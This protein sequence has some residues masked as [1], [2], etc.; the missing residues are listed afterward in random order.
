MSLNLTRTKSAS[1]ATL[2]S[3]FF[4][5]TTQPWTRPTDWLTLPVLQSTDNQF[6]GLFGVTNDSSNIVALTCTT[7][8]GTYTVDWGDGTSPQTYTSGTNAQ[9]QYTY[10]SINSTI[11]S[12][13]FKQVVVKVYPTTVGASLATFSLQVRPSSYLS[14]SVSV[15]WLDIAIAGQSLTNVGIAVTNPL[16][17]AV[18]INLSVLQQITIYSLSSSY[19]SLNQF[20]FSLTSLKSFTCYDSLSS[21]NNF[22]SMFSSCYSLTTISFLNTSA[23]ITFTSMFSSCISL[24]TIPLLNTSAGTNFS[25]MFQNCFSL[26]AIP[27][28]NTSAGT[29]FSNMFQN[30]YSLATIPL[31]NTSAG[32]IFQTMFSSCFSLTTIPLLNTSAGTNFQT[33]FS[34]CFS[35]IVIPLLN[36][37]AGTNFSSMFNNCNSLATIPLLNTSAGTN[38]ASMFFSCTSLTT[39]PLLNTSAGTTFGSM[40]AA[41]FSLTSAALAGT[42]TNIVY[43]GAP[44]LARTELV[45][46]FNNLG[47]ALGSQTINIT[48]CY[49]ASSLTAG[50]RAIATGKGWTI[51]G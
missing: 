26:T 24:T 21:C 7:S 17:P 25:A 37:S 22:T 35:L 12:N 15:P 32:T 19:S 47:T 14:S 51:I 11:T 16:T 42:R 38:F 36:T 10:A 44:K 31:L 49:G 29:I 39:I 46:I 48:N 9:Y 43:S 45:A 30:C 13:G 28:L 6:V 3:R 41:C 23:G 4:P 8:T 2:S 33:M 18:N 34:S 50:E 5:K 27:L 40:F 20:C 1:L